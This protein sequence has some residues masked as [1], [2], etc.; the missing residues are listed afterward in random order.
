GMMAVSAGGLFAAAVLFA[1]KHGIASQLIRRMQLALRIAREDILA[2]LYRT[3]ENPNVE[4]PIDQVAGKRLRRIARNQL[5]RAGSIERRNRGWN[6]TA[7]G[8]SE[9]EALIRTH[10]LWEAFMSNRLNLP[11]N[12]VHDPAD[13]MEH[14][15][16]P[17]LRDLLAEDL[18]DPNLDPQG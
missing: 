14:Y 15:T 13:R 8:K 12:H 1:P 9:A 10:R 7:S 5:R 2:N 3:L 4:T 6:L 11:L 16:D 17:A 18:A